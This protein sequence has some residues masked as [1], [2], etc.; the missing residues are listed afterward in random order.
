L[1]K[2]IE[3]SNAWN[4]LGN[5]ENRRNYD[6]SINNQAYRNKPTGMNRPRVKINPDDWIQYRPKTPQYHQP[7]NYKLHLKEHYEFQDRFEQKRNDRNMKN[8]HYQGVYKENTHNNRIFKWVVLTTFLVFFVAS[9]Y[10][11]MIWL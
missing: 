10:I 4:V 8:E 6:S 7:F 11:E 5:E 9:G 1:K 2:F 3:I